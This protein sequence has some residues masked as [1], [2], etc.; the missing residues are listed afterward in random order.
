MKI[1]LKICFIA[2]LSIFIITC[3]NDTKKQQA[4]KIVR[5]WTGKTV[6][7][8]ENIR[9]GWMGK[10]TVGP[11]L[12]QNEYK[13]LVYIDSTGCTSCK[14]RLSHW[15]NLI[16]EADS[17]APGRISFLFLFNPKDEKELGFILKCDHLEYPVVLDRADEI[18]RLNRFPI[19]DMMFQSFL[20]DKDNKVLLV[21][22]PEMNPKVWKLYKQLITGEQA[23]GNK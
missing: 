14:L 18:N 6:R 22:N 3:N 13:I 9:Y 2:S 4:E 23:I 21:G 17:I 16:E 11:N 7:F 20:L 1:T 19:G 8:P 10:D 5:E 15:K 12:L